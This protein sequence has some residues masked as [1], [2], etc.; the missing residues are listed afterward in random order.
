MLRRASMIGILLVSSLFSGSVSAHAPDDERLVQQAPKTEV[1]VKV[2]QCRRCELIPISAGRKDPNDVW[3]GPRR[4]VGVDA[5]VAF[6]VPRG[7][8]KGLYFEVVPPP[9]AVRINAIPISISRYAGHAPG[10]MV[11]ERTAARARRAFH[12]WA[13]TTRGSAVLRMT[14]DRFKTT[15]F[16]TGE[17]GYTI[18]VYMNPGT[19]TLGPAYQT[20][21]G[22]LAAQD[23]FACR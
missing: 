15:D 9:D 5:R 1:L 6:R 10:A 2:D 17:P 8:T 7:R 13:G 11:S 19:R 22:S 14:I 21:R 3:T 4:R 20:W 23:W 18:R 12:C 16:V